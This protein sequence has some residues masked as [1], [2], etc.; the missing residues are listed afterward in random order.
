MPKPI[1]FSLRDVDVAIIPLR[2]DS[3]RSVIRLDLHKLSWRQ[4][5]RVIQEWR[6][7]NMGQ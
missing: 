3:R 2:E 6:V 5:E 1:K 4:R 7:S